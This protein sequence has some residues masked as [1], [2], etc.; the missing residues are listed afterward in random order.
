MIPAALFYSLLGTKDDRSKRQII[1]C[2]PIIFLPPL[3]TGKVAGNQIFQYAYLQI[4]QIFTSIDLGS[5]FPP[6]FSAP[7]AHFDYSR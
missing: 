4:H 6:V 2:V 1:N 3:L 5:E 7:E